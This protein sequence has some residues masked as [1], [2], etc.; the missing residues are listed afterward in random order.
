MGDLGFQSRASDA[1]GE[2]ELTAD[3][4]GGDE[5]GARRSDV[6]HLPVEDRHRGVVPGHVVDPGGTAAPFGVPDRHEFHS[7]QAAEDPDRLL[8]DLLGVKQVAGGVVHDPEGLGS[9]PGAGWLEAV[10]REESRDIGDPA[11]KILTALFVSEQLAV[12]G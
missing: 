3:V 7:G 6:R 5:V 9:R 1:F 12:L 11:R 8:P 10:L 2:L 4:P